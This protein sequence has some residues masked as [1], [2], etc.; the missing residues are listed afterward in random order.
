MY[1][2]SFE[3]NFEVEI[4]SNW[5]FIELIFEFFVNYKLVISVV[6]YS[7]IGTHIKLIDFYLFTKIS[8]YIIILIILYIEIQNCA[9][10]NSN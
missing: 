7:H 5:F 8:T 3:F 9:R 6:T 4:L 1:R 2:D 10:K